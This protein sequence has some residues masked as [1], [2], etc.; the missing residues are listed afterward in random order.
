MYLHISTFQ[1]LDLVTLRVTGSVSSVVIVMYFI[2]GIYLA[3]TSCSLPFVVTI[4]S[5]VY[6]MFYGDITYTT[7]KSVVV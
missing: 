3:S 2:K 6:G 5:T 1:R 7:Q 4:E